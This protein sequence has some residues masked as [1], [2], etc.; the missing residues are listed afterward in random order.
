VARFDDF[1]FPFVLYQGPVET[2]DVE[3]TG[4]CAACGDRAR[5]LFAKACYGCFRAGRADHAI[6]TELGVVGRAEAEAG[7]TRGVP[8]DDP[9]ELAG[10]D[11]VPR[12]VDPAYPR[13]RAYAVRI[14]VAE[15]RELVTTPRYAT[16]HG[17]RW[18]FH[19]GRPCIFVG[20]V[21]P[22]LLAQATGSTDR[23]I[24][25]R[26]IAALVGA[27]DPDGLDLLE[28]LEADTI[29]AYAFRCQTCGRLRGHHEP[30]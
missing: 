23:A 16:R 18:L 2:A 4:I 26:A 7:L 8:L 12:P 29:S 11:L 1:G 21:T 13:E 25:A 19:C 17:T 24:L 15:L 22:D 20:P 27:P 28:A 9:R 6:D 30:A 3:D 10:Y 5:F 14:P